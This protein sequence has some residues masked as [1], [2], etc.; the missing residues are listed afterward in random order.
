MN[1][2][3]RVCAPPAVISPGM[4]PFRSDVELPKVE[5]HVTEV[6]NNRCS[7]C[8]TAWVNDEQGTKL[9]HVPREVIR[10]QLA[11]AY[12]NGARRALFQGGEPTM[13]RDL[14]D[15]LGD[16]WG[17]GY[18]ATT[19]FTNARMAASQAGARWLT[20]MRVTWFQVSIQG[21]TAAAHD[22]SVVAPG[23]F[24]Q[25]ITGTRRLVAMGQR[26]K[27]NA[28]LTRH[29][30]ESLPS[31][32]DLM[33]EIQP[34][35]VGLDTV[36]PTGAFGVSRADYADLVPRLGPFSRTIADAVATM[37]KAGIVV[38]LTS[39]PPCLAPG[40]ETFV[41]EEPDTTVT[42]GSHGMLLHKRTWKRAMMT[43]GE[44][45]AICAYDS[46]CGGVY[47]LYA[48]QHGLTELRPLQ[49]RA[50]PASMAT[51]AAAD[52]A[53]T[54]AL[55]AVFITDADS[56]P[57]NVVHVRTVRRLTD[58]AH[59]LSIEAPTGTLAVTIARLPP[60]GTEAAAGGR[61]AAYKRTARFAVAYRKDHG[62]P[63]D[64]R[65]V[66]GV[67]RALRRVEDDLVETEHGPTTS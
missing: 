26:V 20:G 64:L 4:T 56:P 11:E 12:A 39:F 33:A 49:R 52:T 23:A 35:E 24:D 55:R 2:V 16:A 1:R 43:K 9:T 62:S 6:C 28:V 57:A 67:V 21:G 14:G 50:E 61:P 34:E 29:L 53:L 27:I 5:I 59:E 41:S 45:C 36:K 51:R 63:P 66:D 48:Q 44:A 37:D 38:R 13:R 40:A 31:F 3:A 17:M 22:A 15:L 7:F 54:R 8:S 10:T 18:E 47:N 32:A 42:R 30:L 19:I 60:P 58:G 46:S 65:I 25:T